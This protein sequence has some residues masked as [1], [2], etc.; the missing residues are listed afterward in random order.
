MQLDIAKHPHTDVVTQAVQT[1]LAS[2]YVGA[3]SFFLFWFEPHSF[4]THCRLH[5][6]NCSPAADGRYYKVMP[7][8]KVW[9]SHANL[10]CYAAYPRAIFSSHRQRADN[11]YFRL[12]R[13]E[14]VKEEPQ[15]R[16]D[17][18]DTDIAEDYDLASGS[19]D[20]DERSLLEQTDDDEPMFEPMVESKA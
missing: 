12:F 4:L 8:A 5:T 7:R 20:E 1:Y 17:Q 9:S 13:E 3:R 19:Q 10:C 2:Q 16:D 15:E 14:T 18:D 11:I 6:S